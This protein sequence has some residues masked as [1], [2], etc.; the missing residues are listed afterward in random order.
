MLLFKTANSILILKRILNNVFSEQ[1]RLS[2]SLYNEQL[3]TRAEHYARVDFE[4]TFNRTDENQYGEPKTLW[5]KFQNIIICSEFFSQ[6]LFEPKVVKEI[7]SEKNIS[8]FKST[9]IARKMIRLCDDYSG[10]VDSSI[11]FH[12]N[13]TAQHDGDSASEDEDINKQIHLQSSSQ[14]YINELSGKE[15]VWTA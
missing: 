8:P 15:E 1:S 2:N 11:N 13:N 12:A 7:R 4:S 9:Q 14:Q 10:D 3:T 6:Y 5:K